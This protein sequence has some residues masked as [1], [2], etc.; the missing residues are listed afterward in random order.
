L[1]SRRAQPVQYAVAMR[2]PRP[3]AD[4]RTATGNSSSFP[5]SFGG[6]HFATL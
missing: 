3:H 2:F 6:N 5:R 1:I 4:F